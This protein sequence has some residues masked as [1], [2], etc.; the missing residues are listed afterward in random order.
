MAHKV[1]IIKEKCNKLDYMKTK[2]I[3]VLKLCHRKT[4]EHVFKVCDRKSGWNSS[5]GIPEC[6]PLTKMED[7]ATHCDSKE[8]DAS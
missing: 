8:M 5:T 1:L 7:P 3:L 6:A 4:S 2:S